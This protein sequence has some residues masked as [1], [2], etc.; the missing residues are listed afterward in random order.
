MLKWFVICIVIAIVAGIFGF[1]GISEAAATIAKVIFF[2]FI[3]GAV[4]FFLL[5]KKIF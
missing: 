5:F 3:I 4:I 2:I 1:G